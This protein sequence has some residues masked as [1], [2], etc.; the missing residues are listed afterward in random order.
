MSTPAQV[1]LRPLIGA[2]LLF[3]AA[4]T[5][6]GQCAALDLPQ[7]PRDG[8]VSWQV[9]AVD[10]APA[11]CCFGDW[12][13]TD[14]KGICQLDEKDYGYGS[15]GRD[16][17]ATQV[18][19]YARFE[20]G[21]LKKLRALDA[22]CPVNAVSTIKPLANVTVGDSARWV[23]AQVQP[24]T[25]E[26]RSPENR[27]SGDA[28]A[29]LAL[30]QG[31]IARDALTSIARKDASIENRR[32]ALFW[33]A[34]VRGAE[35]IDIVTPSL[36]DDAEPKV[37]E[38]AAFAL[39]QSH[40]KTN[41]SVA[42]LLIR[43]ATSDRD[44]KVRSQ[45]WFWLAQ[46]KASETETAIR[47]ALPKESESRVREQAIFALSQLP[48][49]RAAPALMAVAEDKSLAREERKRAIFWLGQ[50]K[51]DQAVAYFDKLL[52]TTATR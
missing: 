4:A 13:D 46:S 36:F 22:A 26:K 43:A 38:H 34:Q 37:R 49:E 10:G 2:A 14:Q 45:A 28:L 1:N 29:A 5:A 16:D 12:R 51:S 7:L 52:T 44:T 33:A 25:G 48:P 6:A 32:N 35:G 27:L 41:K 31:N 21:T 40:K 15:R 3:A 47:A 24:H 17:S 11:W 9:P 19:L 30:H 20:G 50:M 8:W 18:R 42:P 39:S 23:A